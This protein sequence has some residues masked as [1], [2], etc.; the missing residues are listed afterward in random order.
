MYYMVMHSVNFIHQPTILPSSSR[1][2][3]NQLTALWPAHQCAPTK[4][5]APPPSS[6]GY[7]T[8][9]S[10]PPPPNPNMHTTCISSVGD[11]CSVPATCVSPAFVYANKTQ[12]QCN[13][14]N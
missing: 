1:T 5:I 3:T 7:S 6:P 4:L 13:D 14:F 2:E 11:I 10:H 9:M 8:M 12:Q